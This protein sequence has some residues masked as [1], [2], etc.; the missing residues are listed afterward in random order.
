[1]AQSQP[2]SVDTVLSNL[3]QPQPQLQA[4]VE[5]PAPAP[6]T[7][8]APASAQAPAPLRI[9]ASAA[10]TTN[11]QA[12]HKNRLQEY[13]QRSAIALPVYNT[14]NEGYQHAPK[15]R[16]TVLVDGA[17]YTSPNT[18]P[19][20]RAAE[21]DVAKLALEC[22][23]KK[24]KEEGCSLIN[25]DTVFC[26]SIL[27]EFAVKMNLEM[28]TYKT[29]QSEGLLPVFV[30]SLVFDGIAY[31]GETGRNKKEAE[32]LAAQAVIRSLLGTSGFATILFEIIKSKTKLY[33][34]LNKVKDSNYSTQIIATCNV[35][36][37]AIPEASAGMHPSA[38]I[39]V[40]SS[41]MHPT[42]ASP[43]AIAVATA[44]APEAIG[45]MHPTVGACGG[46][47]PTTAAPGTNRVMHPAA[48]QGASTEMHSTAAAPGESTEMHSTAAAPRES[49][50]MHSTAADPRAS[51]G[52]NL[53]YHQFKIPKQELSTE[54]VSLPISFVPPGL[55]EPL[56]V[57]PNPTNKRRK[58]KRKAN[59]K[60]RTDSQ[61]C[62]DAQPLTQAPPCSVTQ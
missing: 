9:A 41:G 8:T 33:A 49:T 47:H 61:L 20:R 2:I 25:E 10:P 19:N 23:S 51:A 14:V 44:A 40:A 29:I 50:G 48:A 16:S 15:F 45:E 7:P 62:V 1:M 18:F 59:K 38:A 12:M 13:A 24:I 5:S 36:T 21:Q 55:A 11:Q 57:G 42:P 39:P 34:A 53:P 17:T 26:K 32:Q 43:G 28:P 60:L 52:M 30:S 37:A 56:G 6:S 31:T 35:P 27:N 22:I 46:M 3:P 58:G 4:P 54:T